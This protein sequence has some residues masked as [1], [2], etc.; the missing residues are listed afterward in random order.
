M[1]R[2][3]TLPFKRFITILAS[4]LATFILAGIL[5]ILFFPK[6]K[7]IGLVSDGVE[8]TIGKKIIIKSIDISFNGI[9][10]KDIV[11]THKDTTSKIDKKDL[12]KNGKNSKN[13][14]KTKKTLV[15]KKIIEPIIRAKEIRLGFSFWSLLDKEF[16]INQISVIDPQLKLT[17]DNDKKTNID[18]IIKKIEEA[19]KKGKKTKIESIKIRNLS[20]TIESTEKNIKI[21]NGTHKI[22]SNIELKNDHAT[23]DSLKIE[24]HQKRGIIKA[25]LKINIKKAEI[26]DGT[27][28]VKNGNPQWIYEH[29]KVNLPYYNINGELTNFRFKDK[30]IDSQVKASS[31]LKGIPHKLLVESF[32]RID[33]NKDTVLLSDTN[34]K[35][36]TS[37]AVIQKIYFSL[38]N[39]LYDISVP[40]CSVNFSDIKPLATIIPNKLYG[41]YNGSF[42]YKYGK[43]S[44]TGKVSN[45]LYDLKKK[46]LSGLTMNISITNNIFKK[47]DVICYI[48]NQPGKVS[49][50][51][52]DGKLE[53]IF[54]NVGFDTFEYKT[55][56]KD[57]TPTDLSVDLGFK[58]T[59]KVSINKLIYNEYKFFKI[60][61]NYSIS[62][63]NLNYS[64]SKLNFL[65]GN[66]YMQGNIGLTKDPVVKS[67]IT[68]NN[69]KMQQVSQFSKKLKNRL[70]GTA[71]GQANISF[72]LNK[73]ILKDVTGTLDI[74]ATKGKIVNTGIQNGLG[75]FLTE[76]KYKL[77]D[78]EFKT[79]YSNIQMN[80]S[81]YKIN[82][83]VFNSDH[84]RLKMKGIVNYELFAKNL[85]MN[86]EFNEY[87]IQDLPVAVRVAMRKWLNGKWYIVPFT[88]NGDIS[89]SKNIKQR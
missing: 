68:F 64:R 51:S 44:A 65:N 66:V 24:L 67:M 19:G 60:T 57:T 15:I 11:L 8:N 34:G 54:L 49:F 53:R 38:K 20:L 3:K 40:K 83:F 12:P 87:F 61:S 73:K 39:I 31:S 77:R 58:V 88:I 33:L 35:I 22:D 71:K 72:H 36:N 84:I 25:N 59:G 74:H 13:I 76:L 55:N 80:K 52:T 41:T 10:L 2:I 28:N 4:L 1:K 23:V 79:V 82:S 5:I 16:V 37:E 29:I 85:N 47:E 70:F 81:I 27:I 89:D 69:V 21:L 43:I 56:P 62:N 17:I 78:L 14:D 9:I 75:I 63:N 32:G 6:Q 48:M 30:V 45:V 46:F 18:D 86:L 50:A 42:Y 26:T 7:I